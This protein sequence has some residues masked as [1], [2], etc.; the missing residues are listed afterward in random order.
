M[1]KRNIYLCSGQGHVLAVSQAD[2]TVQF[3]YDTKQPISFQPA[4][5]DGNVY[6]GT[7]NG[8]LLC[9]KTESPDADGWTAWGGNGRH[10]KKQ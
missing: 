5:A 10:N 9:F 3:A 7:A 1:G 8:M 4:L 6:V 2:G